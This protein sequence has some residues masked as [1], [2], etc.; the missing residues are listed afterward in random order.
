M[1]VLNIAASNG[2]TCCRDMHLAAQL[3]GDSDAG[4]AIGSKADVVFKEDRDYGMVCDLPQDDSYVGL[5]T[6]GQKPAAVPAVGKPLAAVILDVHHLDGIVDLSARPVRTCDRGL[7]FGF[8]CVLE[9]LRHR[10][11]VW[12]WKVFGIEYSCRLQMLTLV[13][14]LRCMTSVCF[15]TACHLSDTELPRRPC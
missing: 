11:A 13:S 8:V 12:F 1:S 6:T 7:Q 3:A 9:R 10:L 15:C 5:I 14:T 2:A 4:P